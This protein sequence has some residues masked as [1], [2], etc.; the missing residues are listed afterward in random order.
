MSRIAPICNSSALLQSAYPTATR[1]HASPIRTR[2]GAR[3]NPC[4]KT[5]MP[6]IRAPEREN[7]STR[8]MK[9]TALATYLREYKNQMH[10]GTRKR[11]AL[12]YT[13]E[14]RT[15]DRLA[16]KP[17]N[18]ASPPPEDGQNRSSEP[19]G[20][21]QKQ[22]AEENDDH[23]SKRETA[24]AMTASSRLTRITAYWRVTGMIK[25]C[26]RKRGNSLHR[27]SQIATVDNSL[28]GG[29]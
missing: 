27:S 23:Y 7:A 1:R 22:K 29:G 13:V 4:A 14:S 8:A 12:K 5:T 16:H 24:S 15:M 28:K 26:G 20:R 19:G 10:P 6:A 11:V 2:R 21:H 9:H 3:M 25:Q 18:R 17:S